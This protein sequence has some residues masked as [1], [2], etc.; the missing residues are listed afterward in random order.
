VKSIE[1][2]CRDYAAG[3][4]S[5]EIVAGRWVRL[6]CERFDRDILRSDWCYRFDAEIAENA[7]LLFPV[8]FR[9]YKGEWEGKPIELSPFQT[10]VTANIMGWV[11]KET[12]LRRFRKA[13][14]SVARKNGKTTWAAGLAIL[15]AF[16]DCEA[17]A[18]VYIGATKKE[19]A[20]ILF[21]DAKAMIRRSETLKKYADVR[22]PLIAFPQSDSLIRPLGSDRPYDGLNPHCTI[23]DEVH[24]MTEQHRKFY[25]TMRTGGGARRQPLDLTITTAGDDKSS[26]WLEEIGY[27]R[28]VM[29]QQLDDEELFFYSAEIDEDDDPLDEA[30]WPKANPVLGDSVK[31]GYLRSMANEAR[32]SKTAMNRF[33]RY[34]CNTQ[35]SSTEQAIDLPAWDALGTGLSDWD[36]ADAIGAGFDLGGRDDLASYAFVA[37]FLVGEDEDEQP[38][39]RYEAWQR[40][41]LFADSKRDLT[42][43]PYRSFIASGLISVERYAMDALQSRLIADCRQMPVEFVGYDPYQASQMAGQLEQEGLKA[44]KMPQNYLHFNE[45]IRVFLQSMQEGRWGHDGNDPLMRYCASN[46]VIVRDRTDRWMFDKSAAKDKIDPIVAMV[47][48]LRACMASKPR[49]AGQLFVS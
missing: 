45:P 35:T 24:A 34:H 18:E 17:A 8:V 36:E 41:F 37:R 28:M 21:S 13:F 11:H 31:I 15:F 48:A 32:A 10:F 33:K 49:T 40:S 4:V 5:G 22:V 46:A 9:H 47:I 19:Q 16:F 20:A 30:C 43:E 25:D 26:I 6:A 42:K 3:V 38:I 14:V 29:E 2:E 23:K 44:I 1:Q 7:C 12:G 27:G 39:Y